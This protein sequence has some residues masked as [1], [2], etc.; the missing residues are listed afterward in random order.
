MADDCSSVNPCLLQG[1]MCDRR[2]IELLQS[3]NENW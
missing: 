2:G 3:T 1:E